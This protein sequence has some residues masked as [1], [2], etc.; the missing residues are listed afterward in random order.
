MNGGNIM[1]GF[2]VYLG[3]DFNE[4]YIQKMI[5]LNYDTIFTSLQIPEENDATKIQ[6]LTSLLSYLQDY[7]ITYIVDINP[8]LLNE[9]LYNDLNFPNANIVIRID[10]DTSIDI[11]NDIIEHGFNCCLNAS[12]VTYKLLHN[13]VQSVSNFSQI[14]YCHNYYP[15]PDTGLDKRYVT[16]QNN[17]ILSFNRDAIIFGFIP[18][19]TKR[20]PL[21]KGLPT[22][23]ET[24]YGKPIVNAH[25][26]IESGI[27]NVIIGD[28]LINNREAESL[29]D[30]LHNQHFTLNVTLLDTQYSQ[31]F[32]NKHTARVDNPSTSI[33]SQEARS[34]CSS[35]I[36]PLNTTTRKVGDITID[37]QLNGRYEGEL[38]LIK[39]ALHSHAHV[40]VA[41]H[42][43]EADIPLIHC[44]KGS[45]T[46]SFNI[47]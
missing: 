44:I 30:F 26:L 8:R 28:N 18:G 4:S 34:Y 21:F 17:L 32:K 40:N 13:L 47:N 1:H 37:N 14:L 38:Q 33:R 3:Q 24:R 41:A 31:I 22:I 42:I 16:A 45:D 46:F 35:S 12:I 9:K 19:T 29:S 23:E 39:T 15:R 27:N 25:D 7:S 36:I 6:Y 2:S 11:V 43:N 20:G 5:D 10:T